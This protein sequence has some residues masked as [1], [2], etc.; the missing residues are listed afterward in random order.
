MFGLFLHFREVWLISLK[1]C[2]LHKSSINSISVRT[3]VCLI[4][5]EPKIQKPGRQQPMHQ[6]PHGSVLV[7]ATGHMSISLGLPCIM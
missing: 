4:T 6:E 5:Q 1:N 3:Q 2:V 7:V